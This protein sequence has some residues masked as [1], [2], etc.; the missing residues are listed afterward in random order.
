ML[1]GIR[2]IGIFEHDNILFL[3]PNQAKNKTETKI[4]DVNNGNKFDT[5]FLF[6]NS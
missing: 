1:N 2:S 4:S 5:E 6:N 3:T